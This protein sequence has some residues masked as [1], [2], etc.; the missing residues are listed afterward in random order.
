MKDIENGVLPLRLL[1]AAMQAVYKKVDRFAAM[2]VPI[3]ITGETGVGK[4]IIAQEIYK[5]S[6]R[7]SKP[8]VV[9][10]C[11]TFP[12]NGLLNSEIFGHER[13]AFTGATHQRKGV[14]EY[15]DTG[16]LFLDEIGD[17]HIEVQPKFL[18][19]LENQEFTRLGSNKAIKTD[20]CIIAA[21]NKNLEHEVE[22]QEFREDLYYRLQT[23]RIHVPPLREHRED[24]H[25]LVD[26]FI[27]EANAQ[28]RKNVVITSDRVRTFLEEA[29][30]PGNIRQLKRTIERAVILTET[31]EIGFSD[32]PASITLT[33]QVETFESPS[34]SGADLLSQRRCIIS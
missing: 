33:P 22:N 17:M 21:T 1:S 34:D 5:K 25:P 30:W 31:D 23:F 24:I 13:G 12:D 3:L 7:R 16:T 2:E 29:P 11:S 32:L 18:R 4:E 27:A 8:F 28:Y 19:L 15:A 26:V 10:N 6:P 20:T 14:F 9:I